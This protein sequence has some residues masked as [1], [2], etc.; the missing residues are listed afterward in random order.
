MFIYVVKISGIDVDLVTR[1]GD[2]P[3]MGITFW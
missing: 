3:A 1:T 2:P